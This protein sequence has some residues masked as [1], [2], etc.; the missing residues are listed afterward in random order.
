[1][2]NT[3]LMQKTLNWQNKLIY[4]WSASSCGQIFKEQYGWEMSTLTTIL[5]LYVCCFV[6]RTIQYSQDSNN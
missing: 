2:L 5:D 1:M 4:S 3:L 6:A